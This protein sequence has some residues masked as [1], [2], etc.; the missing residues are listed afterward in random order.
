MTQQTQIGTEMIFSTVMSSSVQSNLLFSICCTYNHP[1]VCIISLLRYNDFI[2]IILNI[3]KS[4]TAQALFKI[5]NK[6]NT[7]KWIW[8]WLLLITGKN[9]VRGRT[10]YMV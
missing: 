7:S 8:N 5:F 9:S 3:F 4:I 2:V 6:V 10:T 1:S